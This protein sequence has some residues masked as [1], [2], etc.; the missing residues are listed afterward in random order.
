MSNNALK[1]LNRLFTASMLVVSLIACQ[2]MP[3][4]KNPNSQ[5]Q[6]KID[7]INTP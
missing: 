5:P 7:I 4:A 2:E 6:N 1:T 3:E